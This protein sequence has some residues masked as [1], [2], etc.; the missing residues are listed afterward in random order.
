MYILKLRLFFSHFCKNSK[1]FAQF[2]KFYQIQLKKS[3]I[4]LA[5]FSS[6]QITDF[7]LNRNTDI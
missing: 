1:S 7:F 2:E 5:E 6:V 4:F 3:Y